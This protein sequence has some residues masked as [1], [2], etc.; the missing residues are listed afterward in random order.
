MLQAPHATI[1]A[2]AEKIFQVLVPF[3]NILAIYWFSFCQAASKTRNMG[4]SLWYC[5]FSMWRQEKEIESQAEAILSLKR[6][7]NGQFR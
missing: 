1:G 4:R 6:P 3:R 7:H 5:N 2:D